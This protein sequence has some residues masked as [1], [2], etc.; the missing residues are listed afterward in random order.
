MAR[1]H[2]FGL[3]YERQVRLS[4]LVLKQVGDEINDLW[5]ICKT[6]R[7]TVNSRDRGQIGLH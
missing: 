5:A 6:K 4:S 3:S 1:Q 7:I 2:V